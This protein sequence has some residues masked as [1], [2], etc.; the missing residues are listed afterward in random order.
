MAGLWEVVEAWN[1]WGREPEAGVPREVAAKAL[2]MSGGFEAVY[3][4]G[5]RRAG[6]TTVCM[7]L[8]AELGKRHGK[9]ACLY[10]NFEEPSFAGRLEAQLVE[11]IVSLFSEKFGAPPKFVFLDEVQ[12]VEGWEK[13]VRSAVDRKRFKV[14]ATGSSAK[15][16]SS[17]FASTLG[18]RGFG[19]LVLPFSWREFRRALPAS[20]FADYLERGG[21]PAV[22]LEKNSEKR[23]RLLEEYFESAIA[24][25]IAARH[26]VRDVAALRSLAVHALTNPGGPVSYVKMRAM[27]G[28]SVDAIRQYLSFLEEA[29]LVFQVPHFSYSLKKA[30]QKPRKYYAVDLGLRAA[31]A[32]SFSPDLGKKLENAVATG[33]L[34][35]GADFY[36]WKGKREVDFVVKNGAALEAVN[37][38]A[39]ASPPARER[40]GLE[41]FSSEHRNAKTL[42]L[43]GA[44]QV[45][46]W[47]AQS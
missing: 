44:K 17:E 31:V 14:F 41:E 38:C 23:T 15:L 37:V 36:Y 24:R 40:E 33:L 1:F 30:M 42:L 16:L 19:F 2:E 34:G 20:T 18:G 43:A 47:L 10:V 13:W 32:K 28:L 26:D 8:L 6:K 46:A 12:N 3:F 45:E 29:F 22:V 35:R 25:D 27:T 39:S 11:E 7:Q 5:P 21:Y 4:Y 9:R